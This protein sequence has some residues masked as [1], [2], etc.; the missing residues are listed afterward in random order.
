[1]TQ[2]RIGGS[3]SI[4]MCHD[5]V[6]MFGRLPLAVVTITTGPGSIRR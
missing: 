5:I 6:M 2:A 1:M 3:K 4:I